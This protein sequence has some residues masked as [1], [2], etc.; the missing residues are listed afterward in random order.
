[1]KS[2][3]NSIPNVELNGS[4][5]MRHPGNLSLRFPGI[6]SSHFLQ[7]LQPDISASTGSACNSGIENPSYVLKEIGLARDEA[8]SSIR[9]SFGID[10]TKDQINQAT[11]I[12][13]KVYHEQSVI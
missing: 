12:I 10:Q 2:I 9:F 7:C 8:E 11:H 13:S 4:E 6:K 1:M 5:S 3:K